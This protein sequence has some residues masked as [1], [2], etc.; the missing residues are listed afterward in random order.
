MT[1]YL[2]KIER[3]REEQEKS[4]IRSE[5]AVLIERARK[6]G[7]WLWCSYQ[8]LWFSPGELE[9]ENANGSFLWGPVNWSLRDPKA[10]VQEAADEALKAQRELLRRKKRIGLL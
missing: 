7:R 5:L 6:E 2:E 4:A 10:W 9:K 3:A 1:D 8:N